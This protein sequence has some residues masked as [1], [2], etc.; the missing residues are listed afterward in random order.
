[1]D[2]KK[3]IKFTIFTYL[4]VIIKEKRYVKILEEYH[5]KI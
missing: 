3:N 1:M 4:F 5:G 2:G